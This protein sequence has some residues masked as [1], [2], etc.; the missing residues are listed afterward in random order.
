[1]KIAT[2]L[3]GKIAYIKPPFLTL[4]RYAGEG[5][6]LSLSP[7]EQAD[8]KIPSP[9]LRGGGLGREAW[10]TGEAA[11]NY[12]HLLRSQYDAIATG[13]GT[14]LADDPLLTCRLAGLE[15]RSPVR[16]VFDR[17][18]RLPKDCQLMKTADKVPV[19]PTSLPIAETLT[20]LTEKGITRL[21]VEAGQQLSTAFLQSSLVDRI[22]WFRSPA[23]IGDEGLSAFSDGFSPGL[24]QWRQK[25]IL[26]LDNDTLEIYEKICSPAS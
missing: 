21:L 6:S 19:W 14:V 5:I 24:A 22:Y 11:R 16:V 4:P 1:M 25:E 23:S 17:S 10:I 26:S 2:S 8:K 12:G 9:T 18:K 7:A 13:I 3:D 15:D 20:W